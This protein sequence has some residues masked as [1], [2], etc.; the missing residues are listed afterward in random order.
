MSPAF[1]SAF[2]QFLA[3]LTEV[4]EEVGLAFLNGWLTKK[5]GTGLTSL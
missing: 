1:A 2:G 3:V 5:T 4:G